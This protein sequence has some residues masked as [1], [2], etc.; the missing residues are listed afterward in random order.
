MSFTTQTFRG[1]ATLQPATTPDILNP[2]SPAGANTEFS[3]LL[4]DGV[5]KIT[6]RN[7][8]NADLKLSFTS[9]ESGTKYFTISGNAS[10]S[11]ENVSLTSTTLYMQTPG[12]SQ[13]I[14]ILHWS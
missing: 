7:R 1:K 13:T 3:Q 2:V 8:G 6:I 5:K 4:A 10:Y 9:G 11:E 14:E 12:V